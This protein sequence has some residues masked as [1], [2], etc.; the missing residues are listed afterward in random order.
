MH[1]NAGAVT[2]LQQAV[3]HLSSALET[4]TNRD[5]KMLMRSCSY[6]DA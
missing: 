3:A 1:T 2:A 6:T 5:I 4:L